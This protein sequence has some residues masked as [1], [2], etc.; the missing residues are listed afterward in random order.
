MDKVLEIIEQAQQ[1][2][3][4]R[5]EAIETS[6]GLSLE[7]Y[8]R[9]LSMQ[10]HLTRDVQRHF[11][12]IA[13]H[14]SLASKPKLREFLIAFGIEEE[15]HYRIAYKD[16]ENLGYKPLPMPLD[17]QLWWSY[18][19]SVIEIR[20]FVRLGAT[21]I[22]ENLGSGGSDIIKRLLSRAAYINERTARFITIHMH[23][24]LPHGQQVVDILNRTDLNSEQLRDLEEGAITGAILY[25]RML[26]WV[27]M[28]DPLLTI[29]E[30]ERSYVPLLS[31]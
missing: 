15:P 30:K 27:L 28:T 9:Y 16:L 21:C 4:R 6:G 26:D 12:G 29:L 19:D 31:I 24:E 8:V 20:P 7:H 18:F 14:A 17:V 22:L 10:F 13:S 25:L 11:F 3:R 1:I 23:E 2:F 5:L